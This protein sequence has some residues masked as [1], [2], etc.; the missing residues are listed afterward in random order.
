MSNYDAGTYEYEPMAKQA[1]SSAW[2]QVAYQQANFN[3]DGDTS[4]TEA[5][6]IKLKETH[7]YVRMCVEQRSLRVR[8]V[9]VEYADGSRKRVEVRSLMRAGSCTPQVEIKNPIGKLTMVYDRPPG[10]APVVKVFA[11]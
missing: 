9:D 3:P 4:R 8:H 7:K 2:E 5:T 1:G 11:R 6:E 10:K